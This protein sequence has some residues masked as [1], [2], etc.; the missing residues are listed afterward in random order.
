MQFVL[1]QNLIRL[2]QNLPSP[3]YVVGGS[4]RDFLLGISP[5]GGNRDWDICAPVS[6]D[7][8]QKTATSLGFSVKAC[9]KN[10][11]TL[12]LASPSGEHCEFTSFRS[13]KYVRGKHTPDEVF[14]TSD[15]ALD[16]KRRDFT[17]NAV[18]YDI[19]NKK[20]VD[21]LDGVTA[22]REKRL[23]TVA[24]A[25]KVF[26]EDGL[27]LMRLARFAGTLGFTPDNDCLNGAK[28]NAFLIKDI[29]PERIFTELS[30]ILCAD[31]KYGVTFGHYHGLDILEKTGVLDYIIPELTLGRNMLQRPDFHKYDVLT[32]SLL[33]VKYAEESVR[34]A[35]LLHDVGKPFC[36]LRDGNS[37]AHPNEG[38]RI[39]TDIL[40]RLKAPKKVVAQTEKLV[41]LHMYDFNCQVSENKLR[42]FF[43][44]NYPYLKE[45]MLVKQADFS[46]CKDDVSI[47]HTLVKWRALLEKM[48]EENVPFTT[49]DLAVN[50]KDL[51][52][53]GIAP[54]KISTL[55][56]RLLLHVCVNP[57]DNKKARLLRLALKI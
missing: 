43:I 36:S 4:L 30:A 40:T 17:A 18:Y 8:L 22:I 47:A 33:S 32:H 10:T 14:F 41:S 13:D 9:Y 45:L 37:Y 38:A 31:K 11:G 55:L 48:Q 57:I 35:C 16:A 24:P 39:A 44:I 15:I 56:Q 29:Q 25:E 50:G 19:V 7:V 6:V 23:T 20:I 49:K 28:K 52:G 2:A 1:P 51:L 12:K 53:A 21:P 34:L 46:A 42:K 5:R 3:L 26:G 54:T 27:R